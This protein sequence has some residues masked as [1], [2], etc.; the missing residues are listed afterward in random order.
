MKVFIVHHCY[1]PSPDREEIK[2]IGVYSTLEN[3]RAAVARLQIQPGFADYIDGF[4]IDGIDVDKDH[5]TEGF[6]TITN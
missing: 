1:E 6:V 4:S 5:W 3:A 2:L